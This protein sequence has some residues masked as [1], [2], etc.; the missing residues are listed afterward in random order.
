VE[1]LTPERVLR[2]TQRP[3]ADLGKA[4]GVDSGDP[5]A[6]FAENGH[7]SISYVDVPSNGIEISTDSTNGTTVAGQTVI[8]QGGN[9]SGDASGDDNDLPI[10][11]RHLRLRDFNPYSVKQ[12]L[13]E[14]ERNDKKGKGKVS[15]QEP[16][17]IT[18]RSTIEV[19]GI[20]KHDITSWLPYV[21]VVS[22]ELFEV[23][24]VMMDDCRLLLLRRGRGGRLRRVDVLT[25]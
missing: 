2:T 13:E 23:T 19:A 9:N 14:Q 6:R 20:F 11:L 16:F 7:P 10:P 24:D 25:M 21:E 1:S 5:S 22:E 18:E 17:V 3:M 8:T 4:E 15:W 12:R